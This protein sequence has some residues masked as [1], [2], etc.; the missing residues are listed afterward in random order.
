MNDWPHQT[1][2]VADVL[3][4]I[5]AGRRRILLTSPTG[6]GKT[7]I[8]TRL[9]EHYLERNKRVIL[10]T[11]R[12][13]LVDQTSSVLLEA[14]QYH[15]IRAAGHE[16]ERDHPLQ[17]SSIATENSRVLKRKQWDLHRAHLVLVDEAHMQAAGVAQK[18][19]AAHL[20]Q[21][22]AY[23]GFTATPLDLS[24]LYSTLLVAGT[25]SELRACGAL[26]PCI[27]FGPDEPD[28]KKLRTKELG[29]DLSENEIRKV[30]MTPTLWGRVWEWF[31]KLNPDGRP[32]I[33]FAPGVRES[34]WFAEQFER[35]G[36]KAAHIDGQEVWV[37]GKLDRT[38]RI[39]REDI[40]EH[41][42]DGRTT[43]LCN[44]FVLREGID[45]P[46]LSHGI[47]ATI[48][49]SLQSYLQS[50]G[51]LL[52]AAHGVQEV[53]LQDHGGNWWRHGS[54][55]ADR[56]WNLAYTARMVSGLRE[57]RLRKKHEREPFRCPKCGR[58]ISIYRCPCG[59]EVK[60]GTK[61]R[62][63]VTTDGELV[64]HHGDIFKPRR[65]MQRD[66]RALWEKMYYRS[67]TDRGARTF[68]AAAALFAYENRWQWPDPAWP[69]MPV[70][71]LDW[72][73]LVS[74]VPHED[75]T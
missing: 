26:V 49:G 73:R 69:L 53:T 2:A 50:G 56:E 31:K 23:V 35:K 18:I 51:R 60:P 19:L 38:S 32:T 11:N 34:I 3:S 57:E 17:V 55:N 70:N 42:R 13:M 62:P 59:F 44:R 27:H 33:L 41:S 9:I 1:R 48:F 24:Q 74:E 54:L 40:L 21:G 45:A 15:G 71:E 46:W 47:F 29:I 25:V 68:R 64:E 67:R 12:R 72:F 65:V 39:A 22:A 4:A 10:Y 7:R 66:G 36:V 28:L 58:I 63:V 8:M 75:L 16:D 5:E 14:G 37:D 43:V 52:R 30:M 6:G 61:S 20:E